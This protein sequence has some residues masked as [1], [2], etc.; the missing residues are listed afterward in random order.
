MTMNNQLDYLVAKAHIEDLLRAGE[1]ARMARGASPRRSSAAGR[2]MIGRLRGL[3]GRCPDLT[4]PEVQ[5]D[6]P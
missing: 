5:S 3:I 6:C 1:R 4:G 2:G